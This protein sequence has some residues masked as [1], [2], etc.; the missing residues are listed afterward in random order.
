MR[1][2]TYYAVI[3]AINEQVQAFKNSL[4]DE[5]FR[6]EHEGF[7]GG[8]ASVDIDADHFGNFNVFRAIVCIGNSRFAHYCQAQR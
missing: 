8:A 2:V 1:R 5:H 3:D 4:S 7:L 6:T